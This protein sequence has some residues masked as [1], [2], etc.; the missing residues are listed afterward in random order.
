MEQELDLDQLPRPLLH[1]LLHDFWHNIVAT[2][3]KEDTIVRTGFKVLLPRLIFPISQRSFGLPAHFL[4][5]SIF[6]TN[7]FSLPSTSLHV[8]HQ[9]CVIR[10]STP[11]TASAH[12]SMAAQE[13]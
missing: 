1:N 5:E 9:I 12:G 10:S 13:S 7:N 4:N 8:L 3:S 11:T 2:H 6:G